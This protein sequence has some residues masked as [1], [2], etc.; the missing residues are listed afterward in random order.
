VLFSNDLGPGTRVL[1]HRRID[2]RL[3]R[4][5]PFL[6]YEGDPYMV[7]SEGRLYWME[8]AYTT[9][10]SYPYSTPAAAW[11]ASPMPAPCRSR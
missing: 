9:S 3:E 4:I 1:Y 11:T 10:D 5:A 6:R 2:E 7:V 8:D